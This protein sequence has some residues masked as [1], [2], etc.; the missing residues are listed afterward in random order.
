MGQ[1]EMLCEEWKRKEKN[2]KINRWEQKKYI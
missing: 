2:R 1:R